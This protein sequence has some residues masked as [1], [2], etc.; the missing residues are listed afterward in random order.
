[1]QSLIVKIK[2]PSLNCVVKNNCTFVIVN[3]EEIRE[4]C[5]SKPYATESF[6]FDETTLVFKIGGKMFALLDL[7]GEMGINLKCDPENAISLREHY[8]E[9]TPG[10]HMNKKYW[11]S[12]SVVGSL[13][14]SFIKSLIDESY[15]LVLSSLPLKI[16]QH[17]IP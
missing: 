7:E 3:I 17:L 11:N 1:M 6:P 9:I 8:S 10:Y 13:T 2:K 5:I 4:Y 16:Q 14:D 15:L 12:V